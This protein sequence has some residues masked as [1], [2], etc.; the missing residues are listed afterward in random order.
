MVSDRNIY[1][2][3]VPQEEALEILLDKL[4]ECDFYSKIETEIIRV[5]K[6]LNRVTA[7]AVYGKISSPH[8]IAAS[9]DGI[10][11]DSS[12]TYGASESNPIFLEMG[13]QAVEI[14][15][16][17]ILP[18][19]KDSVI[20]IEDVNF[21]NDNK[22]EIISASVP[23]KNVR[24]IGEDIVATEMLFPSNHKIRPYD[25]GAILAGGITEIEVYKLPRVAILPT[26]TELVEPGEKLNPGDIIEYNSRVMSAMISEWGGI[27]VRLKKTID[28]YNKLK[29][30]IQ[31]S[32]VYNDVLIVNAGSSAGRE[33]YTASLIKE[34]GELLVHGVAI[35]PGKPV[36]IGI[37]KG[38][39]VIGIPGF[40]VSAALSF[41]IFVKPL[42]YRL[43]KKSLPEKEKV[44][45]KLSRRVYSPLGSEEY[46]R[47]NIGK[48]KNNYVA[49][50]LSRGAGKIMSLVKAQGILR[51]SRF[52][53]GLEAGEEVDVELLQCLKEIRNSLLII[54]SHDLSLDV[55]NDWMNKIYPGYAIVSSHVGSLGGLLALKRGEAHAA[56]VHL[57]DPENGKYNVSYIKKY[58]PNMKVKLVN[59]AYRDQGLMVKKGNPYNVKGIEDLKRTEITY[60]NRQKG[61]G[62]RVLLDYLLDENAISSSE[63][64][65]YEREE[66]T[67]LNVGAAILSGTAV[68]GMGIKTAAD[69]LGLDFV[70]I[71]KEKYDLCIPSDI[72][73]TDLIN[74]LLQLFNKSQLQ[75]KL[76]HMGYD[77]KSIGEVINC[78]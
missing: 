32:L 51:V 38:K 1:L 56:G 14:D 24:P 26:G 39:P 12:D 54:G 41:E 43:T 45:C 18:E 57:L 5:E 49:N 64:Q 20:K 19:D 6:S 36:V 67:H 40:P 78:G 13:K 65:G 15:T 11:V 42:I 30:E 59:L 74:K 47:V 60:I 16:G 2:Q 9:M 77:I 76:Q 17:D 52:S 35:K 37:V 8:Y 70:P 7:N 34:L 27:P 50:P 61:A 63:I 22:V 72:F 29:K 28:D 66:F 44:K 73:D 10:A 62:T 68:T 48:I 23:W 53:E 75:K 55:L 46:V 4:K 33:D 21:T 58:L 69:A 25:I 71:A 31:N 3:Q